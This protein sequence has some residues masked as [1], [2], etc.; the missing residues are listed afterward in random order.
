LANIL[1]SLS[2]WST[3]EASNQPDSTD[4]ATI[5]GDLRA[6][7]ACIRYVYSQDTIASAATTDLGSKDSGS[8]TI[9]G[10]TTITALGTVSAG[11][12]KSVVF[13]GILTLTHNATSL[14]LP[15]TANITTAANDRAEFESLGGGNWRCNWYVKASGQPIISPLSDGDKGDITV[16]AS[17]ATWTIDDDVIDAATLADSSLGFAMINGTLTASVAANALTVAIKTKAGTDPSATDPV[18]IVFRNA[19]ITDGTYSVVSVTAATSLV[20][21]SGST[22]GT[23]NATAARLAVLLVNNAGTAELAINNLSG[24]VNLDETGVI[25]TTAEGGAGAADSATVVYSTTARTDVAYRVVSIIDITE[26]TAGTWASGP[27][28]L[29]LVG[30]GQTL[31]MGSLGYGQTYQ[32][33][34]VGTQRVGGTT[35]YNT[36]GKPILVNCFGINSAANFGFACYVGGVLIQNPAGTNQGYTPNISMLV[37]PG[38]SY[39]VTIVNINTPTWIELR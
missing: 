7:Q 16:S 2:G 27:T 35:Y 3:T 14:I 23:V 13:S 31:A 34:T 15:G 29:T 24:G 28:K 17:G 32:S 30:A 12:R 21:S 39:S 19:T 9:S 33:F 38:A 10:T 1:P 11:I 6:I 20:V 4:S 26:A 36:T 37:P 18:L 5:T 25:S 22:L 8:L